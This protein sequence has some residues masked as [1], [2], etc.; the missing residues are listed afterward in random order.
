MY[1]YAGSGRAIKRTNW[2]EKL[3]CN[4][5]NDLAGFRSFVGSLSFRFL[6]VVSIVLLAGNSDT[7]E[8]E[9]ETWDCMMKSCL[10]SYHFI[11]YIWRADKDNWVVCFRYVRSRGFQEFEGF[12]N[13]LKVCYSPRFAICDCFFP[14]H[15]SLSFYIS[16]KSC[17]I[18][19]IESEF[20]YI[21]FVT[22]NKSFWE[23]TI[24]ERGGEKEREVSHKIFWAWSLNS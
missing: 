23:W 22:V 19:M 9:K 21:H 1:M 5:L 8:A 6:F 18:M 24:G 20:V 3:S 17:F 11:P 13:S 10:Y 16:L 7:F 2:T 12:G 15:F 14:A 4:C